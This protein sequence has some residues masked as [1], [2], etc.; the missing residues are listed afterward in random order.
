MLTRGEIIKVTLLT[1]AAIGLVVGGETLSANQN[2]QIK[3]LAGKIADA[4]SPAAMA[5]KQNKKKQLKKLKVDVVKWKTLLADARK[6]FP[7][8]PKEVVT[9]EDV[10]GVVS[11]AGGTLVKC[12]KGT[13]TPL[14]WNPPKP[15]EGEGS[16]VEEDADALKASLVKYSEDVLQ[17][18]LSGDY[19]DWLG[20]L[21]ELE[22]LRKFYRFKNVTMKS[23]GGKSGQ[24]PLTIEVQLASY[25]VLEFPADRRAAENKE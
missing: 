4:G 12:D 11:N 18:K 20:F 21:A 8:S 10:A 19:Q 15:T 23:S 25:H 1:V 13:S 6:F 5:E 3:S 2:A 22:K 17:L 16:E 7:K 14:S 9:Q 24:P